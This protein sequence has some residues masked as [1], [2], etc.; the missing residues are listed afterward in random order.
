MIPDDVQAI[1]DQAGVDLVFVPDLNREAW[2]LG[3]DIQSGGRRVVLVDALLTPDRLSAIAYQVLDAAH[4][5]PVLVRR[6]H[7][8]CADPECE[9]TRPKKTHP[10]AFCTIC[11]EPR[12][13]GGGAAERTVKCKHCGGPTVHAVI[14]AQNRNDQYDA[15]I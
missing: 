2:A 11:L 1:L 7:H 5:Q 6:R 3:D 13:V 14:G 15:A 10:N 12:F 8:R 4:P 9:S